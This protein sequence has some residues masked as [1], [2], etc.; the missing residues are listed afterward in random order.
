MNKRIK[1]YIPESIPSENKG[2]EAILLGL[3]TG[4][5][6]INLDPKIYLFSNNK[7]VDSKNYGNDVKVVSGISFRPSGA[8]GKSVF[9]RIVNAINIWF[10]HIFFAIMYK[11]LKEKAF[12]FFKSENW[13]A[14]SEADIILTGHDGCISDLNIFF[15]MFC[16]AIEK[17]ILI[18]GG[19]FKKFRFSITEKLARF[20][21]PKIDLIVVRQKHSYEYLK[22]LINAPN[23]YWYPDPAFLMEP[24][25][26]SDLE[27]LF[28]KENLVGA[29]K[30]LIGMIA[31]RGTSYYPYFYGIKDEELRYQT[32]IS[33][34]A[35]MI[36]YIIKITNGTVIFIPHCIRS[37]LKNDDREVARDIKSKL[38]CYQDRVILVEKEYDARTLKSFIGEL[39][40][41][42][43]QRLHAVIGAATVG[44]PFIQ[45]TVKQDFRSHDIIEE[46][47]GRKDLVYDLDNNDIEAFINVFEDKWNTKEEIKKYLLDKSKEIKENCYDAFKLLAKVIEK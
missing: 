27:E 22:F 18:F 46:T 42:I 12:Y 38:T 16:K 35:R 24:Y 23:I 2:E 26:K 17:K 40:F 30:P 36:E 15:A 47:I 39:D 34:F 8:K 29:K 25:N 3:I 11:T 13:K 19:G 5:K 37:A 43:S 28:Q 20:V 41:L 10:K 21:I 1:I 33:F 45:L 14:Y 7:E 44:T 31:V 6:A 9:Q 32:H 4:I